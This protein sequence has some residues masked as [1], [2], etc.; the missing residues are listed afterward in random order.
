MSVRISIAALLFLSLGLGSISARAEEPDG[1]SFAAL[2]Y[3]RLPFTA[4]PYLGVAVQKDRVEASRPATRDYD[5]LWAQPK[6]IDVHLNPQT[7][8]PVRVNGFDV[9]LDGTNRALND[10]AWTA[11]IDR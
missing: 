7:M 10:V 3:L 9:Y 11:H 4:K 1:D 2:A 5:T 8:E 6:V